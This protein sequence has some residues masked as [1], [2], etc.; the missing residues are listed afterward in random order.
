MSFFFLYFYSTFPPIFALLS[1]PETK[2]TRLETLTQCAESSQFVLVGYFVSKILLEKII[3]VL[4]LQ[5]DNHCQP[6]LRDRV[7]PKT[8]QRGSR[9]TGLYTAVA[10]SKAMSWTSWHLRT[11]NAWSPAQTQFL[12]FGN[13]RTSYVL[14]L[15]LKA[16]I[17]LGPVSP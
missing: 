14:F 3:A 7:T 17:P 4:A 1:L 15:H 8:L 5:F 9:L 13:C 10:C 12:F 2:R 11:D 16:Q 6:T